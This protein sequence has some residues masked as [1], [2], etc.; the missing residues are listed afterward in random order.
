M[1]RLDRDIFINWILFK[2]SLN[3]DCLWLKRQTTFCKDIVCLTMVG[4]RYISKDNIKMV[5]M[6]TE[7][8]P[9]HKQTTVTLIVKTCCKF[10][11]AFLP[12]FVVYFFKWE[13]MQCISI[14]TLCYFLHVQTITFVYIIRC[15]L[16]ITFVLHHIICLMEIYVSM[17]YFTRFLCS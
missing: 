14:D 17:A 16:Y 12:N 13:F 5:I 7:Y 2:E 8:V 9:I 6:N 15:H 4:K 1:F 10:V 11:L 3:W